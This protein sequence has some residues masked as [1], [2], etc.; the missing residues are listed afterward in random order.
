MT[1]ACC[2][3]SSTTWLFVSIA[4]SE[5]GDTVRIEKVLG[6][7]YCRTIFHVDVHVESMSLSWRAH[8]RC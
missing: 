7:L 2:T 4:N 5:A 1:L 3:I 6:R 8:Y